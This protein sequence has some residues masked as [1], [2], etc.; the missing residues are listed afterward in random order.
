MTD[1]EGN[2]P[3]PAA[4]EGA[5]T[6]AWLGHLMR[7][8]V[9][10]AI[11]A[12]VLVS[13]DLGAAADT[14]RGAA[15]GTLAVGVLML[16]IH[17]L[18]CSLRW[19]LLTRPLALS[20]S[21]FSA[22]RWFTIT[23]MFNQALPATVGGDAVRV[24]FMIREGH[25]GVAVVHSIAMDRVF[26]LAG[27]L[28]LVASTTPLLQ[29]DR[30]VGWAAGA[31]VVTIAGFV[32]AGWLAMRIA[33][34]VGGRIGEVLLASAALVEQPRWSILALVVAWWGWAWAS[35]AAW[36][37]ALSLGVDVGWLDMLA[38]C[39]PVWLVTAFPVSIAGW[40]VREGAMV[41]GLAI[42]GVPAEQALAV[43]ILT[44]L[45][46]LSAGLPGAAFWLFRPRET[47]ET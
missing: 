16:H 10:I 1:P 46:N 26:A 2:P 11:G 44:G 7:A 12:V 6:R 35:T 39:G 20:L 34:H 18:N 23:V 43:S 36:V 3:L 45:S 13:V 37:L 5:Q 33:P 9:T 27:L 19:W 29:S 17:L 32:F 40:G 15:W 38:I 8:A 4:A 21:F 14:L 42:V 31:L 22:V 30:Q 25:K 24:V 41:T 47:V 28:A